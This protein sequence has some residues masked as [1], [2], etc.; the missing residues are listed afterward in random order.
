MTSENT[1]KL[2]K[3]LTVIQRRFHRNAGNIQDIK[4]EQ[5]YKKPQKKSCRHCK[6]KTFFHSYSTKKRLRALFRTAKYSNNDYAK[7]R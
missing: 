3:R 4:T 5:F 2:A 6:N 7:C 1:Q